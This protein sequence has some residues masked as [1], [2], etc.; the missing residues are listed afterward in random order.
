MRNFKTHPNLKQKNISHRVDEKLRFP[1][2]PR[3]KSV[4]FNGHRFC[5][6][7]VGLCFFL[8]DLCALSS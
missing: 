4:K 6:L 7:E 1:K 8:C 5:F 3:N 2:W